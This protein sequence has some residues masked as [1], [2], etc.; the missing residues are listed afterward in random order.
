MGEKW[1]PRIIDIDILLW[2]DDII[3]I[4][5]LTI[6]H[7]DLNNRDFFLVPLLELN[8]SLVHPATGVLLQSIL[9]EIPE[10]LRTHPEKTAP[11]GCPT[12][13]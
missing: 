5:Q 9:D 2:A 1:E 13:N 12:L 10:N 7:Y 11:I 4:P 6:P 3:E 8:R